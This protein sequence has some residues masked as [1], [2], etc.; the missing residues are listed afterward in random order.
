MYTVQNVILEI[1]IFIKT[2]TL[3]LFEKYPMIT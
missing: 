3:I 1:D 2:F